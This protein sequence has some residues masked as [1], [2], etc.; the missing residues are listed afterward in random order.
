VNS[1]ETTATT[2]ALALLRDYKA[3]VTAGLDDDDNYETEALLALI[4]RDEIEKMW[5]SLDEN[6]KERVKE[7]DEVLASKHMRVSEY[8]S[9][10]PPGRSGWWWRLDEGPQVRKSGYKGSR[11]KG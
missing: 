2:R 10:A 5:A 8:L 3:Y 6:Q 9:Y 11:D 1:L 7:L 4:A